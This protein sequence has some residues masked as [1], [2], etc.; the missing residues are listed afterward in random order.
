MREEYSG[1]G[2]WKEYSGKERMNIQGKR[3][4]TNNLEKEIKK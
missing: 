1:K 2:V 3:E 4:N